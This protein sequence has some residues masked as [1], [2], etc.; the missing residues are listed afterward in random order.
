MTQIVTE[1]VNVTEVPHQDTVTNK[2]DF[3]TSKYAQKD[4]S[5]ST[6]TEYSFKNEEDSS[7]YFS[8]IGG[9]ILDSLPP[10]LEAGPW[11]DRPPVLE[12]GSWIENPQS[13]NKEDNKTQGIEYV[14]SIHDLEYGHSYSSLGDDF[15]D[16]YSTW[17]DSIGAV[18]EIE[19]EQSI[20]S[21]TSD[22][23]QVSGS[24]LRPGVVI[25]D[26][27]LIQSIV[28]NDDIDTKLEP[29]Y[30]RQDDYIYESFNNILTSGSVEEVPVIQYSDYYPVDYE[31]NYQYGNSDLYQSDTN[32][33]DYSEENIG[34]LPEKTSEPEIHCDLSILL[35]GIS[36]SFNIL[37]KNKDSAA[38]P[39]K[40]V[41]QEEVID[42]VPS[43]D[44]DT[45]WSKVQDSLGVSQDQEWSKVN[46]TS[47][48]ASLRKSPNNVTNTNQKVEQ[49]IVDD[50]I[51][52]ENTFENSNEVVIEKVVRRVDGSTSKAVINNSDNAHLIQ[53]IIDQLSNKKE[54]DQNS[55]YSLKT[56]IETD[57]V[58][59]NDIFKKH[60]ET[61][62][63][64][65]YCGVKGKI[66]F[67]K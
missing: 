7:S 2:I 50:V 3:S 64:D 17:S 65:K 21:G 57:Q 40:I 43:I 41:E 32:Y 22:T 56:D 28:T 5:T 9:S 61:K 23:S 14:D 13:E 60:T 49:N 25:D 47:T 26:P 1:L 19:L 48:D 36:C 33:L 31:P 16:E 63:K 37:D 45:I 54:N 30:R 52:E 34:L 46:Q 29:A 66:K 15:D 12:E 27:A 51:V 10:V 6:T 4:K 24:V 38:R 62:V 8:S 18:Y 11:V 42:D 67:H 44:T 39:L 55:S 53:K 20:P 59:I 58:L 35:S